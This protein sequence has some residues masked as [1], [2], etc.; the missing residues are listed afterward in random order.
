MSVWPSVMTL[1]RFLAL[2]PA[3]LPGKAELVCTPLV[4][5]RGSALTSTQHLLRDQRDQPTEHSTAVQRV[6][7]SL[8]SYFHS[9]AC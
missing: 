1:V 9:L 7:P 6:G 5:P 2:L 4:G 8:V 3:Y